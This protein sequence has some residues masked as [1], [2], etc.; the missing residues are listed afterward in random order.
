MSKVFDFNS[1]QQHTL[2]ITLT[3]AERTK[4]HITT[5]PEKLIEQLAA[6]VEDLSGLGSASAQDKIKASYELCA[7]LMSCNLEN[8]TVTAEELKDKNKYNVAPVMLAGFCAAYMD[9]INDFHNA[10]N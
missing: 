3:D 8:I 2:E 7:D 5:P 1:Y 9:F 4:L 6:S 10:K